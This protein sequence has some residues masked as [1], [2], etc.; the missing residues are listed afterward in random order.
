[1]MRAEK[2]RARRPR[3]QPPGACFVLS[4]LLKS[5]PTRTSMSDANDKQ[6]REK[7]RVAAGGAERDEMS[8]HTGGERLPPP[9]RRRWAQ[10]RLKRKTQRQSAAACADTTE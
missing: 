4:L 6:K 10:Q 2:R 8:G 1:M 5:P 9:M 7:A 3:I